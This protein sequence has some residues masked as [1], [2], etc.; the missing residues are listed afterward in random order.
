MLP[1]P[2]SL[3]SPP[4]DHVLKKVAGAT[5]LL[6]VGDSALCPIKTAPKTEAKLL[7]D[8]ISAGFLG[9][10]A[11][12]GLS[13]VQFLR[14]TSHKS[15]LFSGGLEPWLVISQHRNQ[16]W[17]RKA[18]L[19]RKRL[20]QSE[21]VPKPWLCRQI[22]PHIS[23][24]RGSASACGSDSPSGKTLQSVHRHSKLST[25]HQQG[26]QLCPLPGCCHSRSDRF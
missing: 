21:A 13:F 6:L 5:P 7:W 9:R 12:N 8:H 26:K 18:L 20:F 17:E 1:L 11:P 19:Y 25:S 4:G 10:E 24:S 15:V 22:C 2:S 3:T 23:G 16:L 14:G